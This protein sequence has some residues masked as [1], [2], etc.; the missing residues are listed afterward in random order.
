M[1]QFRN[2]P[3]PDWGGWGDDP[4]Y[5]PRNDPLSGGYDPGEDYRRADRPG[6][7]PPPPRS[8]TAV[9]PVPAPRCS[10]AVARLPQPPPPGQFLASIGVA[11]AAAADRAGDAAVRPA[12]TPADPSGTAGR[13]HDA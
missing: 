8:T 7:A 5:F 6:S 3:P 2:S 12:A 11:P 9:R 13:L 1:A 4:L 10:T